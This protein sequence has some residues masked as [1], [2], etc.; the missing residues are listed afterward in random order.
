M[1]L[2]LGVCLLG[3]GVG[4]LGRLGVELLLGLG[5]GLLGRL[6]VKLL[7]GRLSVELLLSVCLLGRLG[8]ELLLGLGI[9]LL[10]GLSIKLL[11]GLLVDWLLLLGLA[12]NVAHATEGAAKGTVSEKTL[13]SHA[14]SEFLSE[15]AL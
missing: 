4:L 1:L 11:L 10:L 6:S 15:T 9:K 13:K 7:L 5:V 14:W 3:L 12:T 2:R 8:V